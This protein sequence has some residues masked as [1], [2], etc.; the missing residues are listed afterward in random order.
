MCSSDASNYSSEKGGNQRLDLFN[1]ANLKYFL[2]FCQKESFFDAIS[3]WP[4]F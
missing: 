1:F 3:K 4:V 2:K